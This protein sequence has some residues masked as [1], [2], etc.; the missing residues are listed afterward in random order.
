MWHYAPLR[1]NIM[2]KVKVSVYFVTS[3][4]DFTLNIAST[5]LWHKKE[6][7][8]ID[9]MHL[10]LTKYKGWIRILIF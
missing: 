5:K 8:R 6:N 10:T 3:L 4:F 1:M 2:C 7:R 9:F